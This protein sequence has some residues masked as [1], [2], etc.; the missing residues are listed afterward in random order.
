MKKC[1]FCS[2]ENIIKCG[3]YKEKQRFKCKNC[4]KISTIQHKKYSDEFKIECI[5]MSLNSMGLR[6][7]G[8]VKNVHN[9]LISYWIKKSAEIA[10]EKIRKDTD[11]IEKIEI[12][13]VDELCTYIKKNLKMG[14]NIRFYGLLST[15]TETKL[16]ILN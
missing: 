12:L 2:S 5:K 16:L 9:S 10:K 4:R 8:R 6:A 13:E 1:R 14:V 15:E 3:F 7:I 11:N